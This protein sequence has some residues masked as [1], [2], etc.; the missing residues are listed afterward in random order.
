MF[1]S[2]CNQASELISKVSAK[3]L[4]VSYSYEDLFVKALIGDMTE[5]IILFLWWALNFIYSADLVINIFI[6]KSQFS[7]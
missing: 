7:I 1:L 4:H 3:G 2:N 5:N 6:I